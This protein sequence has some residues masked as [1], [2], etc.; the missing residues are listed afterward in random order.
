MECIMTA[1]IID[2]K[3]M[4]QQLREQLAQKVAELPTVPHLAVIL[5]GNDEASIIYDRNKQKAAEAI[6][7]KCTIHHLDEQTPQDELLS[8]I[9]QLNSDSSING[10]IVQMPLPKHL[11]SE[12]IIE[13]IDH[14][15]DVDGFGI[16]N[17]GLLHSNNSSA[18]VAATPQAVLY[19]LQQTLGDIVG[20]HAVIIGRSNI[21][22]RPLASLL[23][24]HHCTVTIAHSKTVNLSQIT[25]SADIVVAA[26]G[27]AGL[28]KKDWVKPGA[29][30]IDVGINRVNGKLCGDVDFENVKEVASY[31]T[32]VPGGVGPMTVTMLLNNTLQAY[33]EQNQ[34]EQNA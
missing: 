20:K 4:A 2:G 16:Y 26:C 5:V 34:R 29:T 33:L 31:I 11:N 14:T 10:I 6:G 18:M 9:K 30:V 28:V 7:M 22:G 19:M 8:L 27:V 15:K 21:V 1:Q 3:L 24:N 23:L 32:P 17:I 12:Q 13:S 25:A